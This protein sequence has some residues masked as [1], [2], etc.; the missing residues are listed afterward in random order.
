MRTSCAWRWMQP[1]IRRERARI[2]E[3]ETRAQLRP[4]YDSM[5]QQDLQA[6]RRAEHER[7]PLYTPRL[8]ARLMKSFAE[9]AVVPA[10]RGDQ[11]V[12]RAL[13]RAFHML[14][15]PH[16]VAQRPRRDAA[17]FRDVGAMPKETKKRRGLYPP[18][19]GPDRAEMFAKL[20]LAT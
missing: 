4:Y 2:V 12:S 1:P 19:F 5:V 17:H 11:A 9:D 13:T 10:T 3:R 15:L 18:S 16:R 6:I 14:G 7:D 8:K 20:G